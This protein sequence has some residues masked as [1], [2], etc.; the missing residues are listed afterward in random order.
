[1]A[2]IAYPTGRPLGQ[3]L[4]AVGQRVILHATLHALENA[5]RPGAVTALPFRWPEPAKAVR[6]S[7]HTKTPPIGALI[8]KKPWL[9]RNLLSGNIPDAGS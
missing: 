4:D 1:M 9:Y 8:L 6:R 7:K 3:P 2:G 5:P